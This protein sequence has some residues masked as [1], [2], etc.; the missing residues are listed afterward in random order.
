MGEDTGDKVGGEETELMSVYL[1]SWLVFAR[2]HIGTWI[3]QNVESVKP[4]L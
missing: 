4:C 2:C 3:K 1:K